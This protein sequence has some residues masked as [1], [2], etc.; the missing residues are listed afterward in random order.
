MSAKLHHEYDAVECELPGV[1]YV[2]LCNRHSWLHRRTVDI[3]VQLSP[4]NTS[5]NNSFKRCHIDGNQTE[6]AKPLLDENFM[7]NH[8][9]STQR[10]N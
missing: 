8:R 10:N 1:Y 9:N 5:T 4:D 3:L 7:M 6:L 2:V